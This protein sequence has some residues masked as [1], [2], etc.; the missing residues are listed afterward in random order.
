MTKVR[1]SNGPFFYSLPSMA[2]T[3]P[4][5]LKLLKIAPGNFFT[6]RIW[7]RSV[8][9]LALRPRHSEITRQA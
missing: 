3:L 4:G 2:L 9:D 7:R 6:R 8:V 1:L 5:Q